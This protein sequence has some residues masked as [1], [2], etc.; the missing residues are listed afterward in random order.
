MAEQ[1]HKHHKHIRF[2]VILAWATLVYN[3]VEGVIS[4]YFGFEERSIALAGFGADSFVEAGSAIVIL[5]RLWD[6][7]HPAQKNL[8][9]ERLATKIIGSLLA[10]L[11]VFVILWAGIQ[12][13]QKQVPGTTI[14]GVIIASISICFMVY[15]WKVKGRLADILNSPAL[16]ADANCARSCM[17]LSF[18]L[19]G[20]SFFY[21]LSPS[22]WWIDSVAAII[23]GVLISKEGI[24]TY[25]AAKA[26]DFDGGCGCHH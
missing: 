10:F 13:W 16:R 19:L 1:I 20:G 18:I 7:E 23:M 22:L 21:W 3:I 11:G 12:L 17:N 26:A 24:E 25:Q 15:F 9:K 8:T 2:A 14:P 4:M 6:I 5:W